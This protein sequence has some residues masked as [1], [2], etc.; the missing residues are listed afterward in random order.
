MVGTSLHPVFPL[1][2]PQPGPPF[3]YTQ[4]ANS[5]GKC[6]STHKQALHLATA[7]THLQLL[8]QLLHIFNAYFNV[9]QSDLQCR[10]TICSHTCSDHQCSYGEI[11]SLN[12][13]WSLLPQAKIRNVW[14]WLFHYICTESSLYTLLDKQHKGVGTCIHMYAC[15][16]TVLLELE[17]F[18]GLEMRMN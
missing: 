2:A 12:N 5:N 1:P 15:R 14:Y 10:R 13:N 3:W 6:S 7:P 16:A 8:H 17:M 18:L 9:I 4:P 11:I